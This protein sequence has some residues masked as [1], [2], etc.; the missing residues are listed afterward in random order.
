M[1]IPRRRA[2]SS[3]NGRSG[4]ATAARRVGQLVERGFGGVAV[5]AQAAVLE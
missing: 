4:V 1:L 5:E 3:W 2:A